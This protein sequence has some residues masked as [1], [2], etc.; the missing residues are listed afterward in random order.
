MKILTPVPTL[1]TSRY[2][3]ETGLYA[4]VYPMRKH[5]DKLLKFLQICGLQPVLLA[6]TPNETHC[7]VMHSKGK[8][9]PVNRIPRIDR[10]TTYDAQLKGFT[11]WPGHNDKGYLVAE[12]ES[13]ALQKLH[14]QWR[15]LGCEHLFPD[16][17]P[18]VTV[19]EGA[20]ATPKLASKLNIEYGKIDPIQLKFHCHSFEDISE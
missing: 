11:S 9:I 2:T 14:K 12:M 17:K 16:Y 7:T 15:A 1:E 20:L 3:G 13:P 18:H 6:N 5:L 4:F 8:S 10:A 19:L